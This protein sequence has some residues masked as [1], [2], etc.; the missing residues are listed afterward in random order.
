MELRQLTYFLAAAHTQSF[1][2]AATLCLVTQ[3]ALSRQV[4]ALEAELGVLLFTRV[5]QHV[6]L[7]SAGQTFVTYARNILE[8]LQLGQQEMARLQEGQSGTVHIG[9]N[10]SLSASFLPPL[11]TTFRELHPTVRLNV[12]VRHSDEVVGLV[13]RS[14]VDLGF[15]FDPVV[16]SELVA[17]KELFRQP[18]HLLVSVHHPLAR[19]SA[20][21]LEQVISQPLLL[22]DKAARLRK[23]LDHIFEQRKLDVQPVIEIGTAEGLRELVRSGCGVTLLPPALLWPLQ[24]PADLMLLPVTD[25]SDTF[26]FALIYRRAGTLT[27]A[28]RQF[29][30][31]VIDTLARQRSD[32]R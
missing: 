14:E 23:A 2:K 32:E 29:M 26:V 20:C 27:L 28:A 24:L 31:L 18:L 1:R 15:I 11:L 21:I 9:C 4:A 30:N 25:V 10:Y 3:P 6:V 17:V 13:E 19:E 7:T 8:E 5:K 22:L 12:E 16:H